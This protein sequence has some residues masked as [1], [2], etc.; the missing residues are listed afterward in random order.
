VKRKIHISVV[1]FLSF[2]AIL[3]SCRNTPDNQADV[4]RLLD[5]FQYYKFRSYD[6]AF[7][8]AD[9]LGKYDL[10]QNPELKAKV[11]LVQA[12]VYFRKAKYKLARLKYE[13]VFEISKQIK[14]EYYSARASSGFASIER[15]N[16]DFDEAV[17]HYLEAL[18]IYEKLGS[19]YEETEANYALALFYQEKG[20]VE[21]ADLYLKKTFQIL[22]TNPDTVT[23]LK[24]N[25]VKANLYGMAG[26]IDSALYIDSI[27]M[28]VLERNGIRELRP[29]FNDNKGLCLV[30][31]GRIDEAEVFFRN[32]L[33]AD[34]LNQELLMVADD[35]V[36]LSLVSQN[37][38]K[39]LSAYYYLDRAIAIGKELK[40]DQFLL[41]AYTNAVDLT[42]QL[43]DYKTALAYSDTVLVI[44]QRM[45]DQK[46][47]LLQ[48]ELNEAYE[49]EKKEALIR[50]NEGR[51]FVYE[52]IIVF[53][54]VLLL[55]IIVGGIYYY[56][57]RMRILH[58]GNEQ[59][60]EQTANDVR[61]KIS[62]D[63]HD[64]MGAHTTSIISQI[65][66]L[67]INSGKI[68]EDQLASLRTDA[69][70][71]IMTL[72]DSI[73]VLKTQSVTGAELSERIENY[74]DKMLEQKQ[75][76]KLNFSHDQKAD[77]MIESG[78]ALNLYRITQEII[79]NI[80][81][82]ARATEVKIHLSTGNQ[83][84]LLIEDNGIGFDYEKQESRSGL[85]N[86]KYRAEE[87]SFRMTI[88]SIIG[89]GT[90]IEIVQN[91][92]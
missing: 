38:K 40:S 55:L 92:P 17:K 8:I 22:K 52:I 3:N 81:K 54:S 33:V 57:L 35:Y 73:W 18:A 6:S 75:A 65:D 26:K 53:T 51:V 88:N 77:C 91:T 30:Y 28:L 32:N 10:G 34:S 14:S 87:I 42:K 67:G 44:R 39:F 24:S 89:K 69:E 46:K 20:D 16:G 78:V 49:N 19:K 47:E 70:N 9:S 71:I 60:I 13:G 45:L 12:F 68:N 84:D 50:E 4:D 90:R 83:I 56:R 25:H 29:K 66:R 21:N 5:Q 15:V 59:K 27:S 43:P 63:L 86:L 37:Q 1:I 79:Q 64:N 7:S 76:I 58:L 41:K 74:A 82:H 85:D 11:M 48:V 2:L 62:R 31:S 23:W 36:Q 72:R 80:S 61:R